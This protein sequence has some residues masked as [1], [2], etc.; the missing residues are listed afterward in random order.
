M[1]EN[2]SKGKLTSIS[3]P[4]VKEHSRLMADAEEATVESIASYREVMTNLIQ[5]HHGSV[6]DAKGD[7]VLA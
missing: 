4:D 1:S 3:S 5:T 6:K 7:N 2:R